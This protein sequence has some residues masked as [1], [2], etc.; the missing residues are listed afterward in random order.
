MTIA[1]QRPLLA[2]LQG[3]PTALLVSAIALEGIARGIVGQFKVLLQ[4][5]EADRIAIR[6]RIKMNTSALPSE[7]VEVT[8][9]PAALL[10]GLGGTL[11][12]PYGKILTIACT[13]EWMLIV[14]A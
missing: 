14:E 1:P 7:I 12:F 4:L 11:L 13:G 2:Q 8:R 3:Y 6:L 10:A 9:W 5:A